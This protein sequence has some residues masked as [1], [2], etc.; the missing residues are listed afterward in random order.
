MLRKIQ[1]GSM[2]AIASAL[3]TAQAYAGANHT[4]DHSFGEPGHAE[5]VTRT[6][7]VEAHDANGEMKFVH[8]PLKIKLGET[9]K[10]VVTN[11]GEMPHEFA[12]GD[13]PT[14]RAHA[15]MMEKMPDMKHEGDPAVVT[16]QPGETKEVIWTFNK[17][18]QGSIE[19]AC[20]M[21]GHY[22]GGMVSKVSLVK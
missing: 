14:Q 16:L 5:D 17:P 11:K 2:I 21:P 9:V 12:L 4:K 13:S 22:E 6:V 7:T 20:Q 8:E 18:V 19:L 3:I 1:L 10:F 15:L